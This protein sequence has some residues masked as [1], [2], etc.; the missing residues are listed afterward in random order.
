MTWIDGLWWVYLCA[1]SIILAYYLFFFLRIAL[2]F[3]AAKEEERPDPVSVIIAA[4]NEAGNLKRF[5]PLIM[6]QKGVEFEVVVVNDCS[7][8][9]TQ[10]VLHD[11]EEKYDNFRYTAFCENGD[12]EG[13]KKLAV[14]LGIKAAQYPN[15]V[16]TDADC[17][18]MSEHWLRQMA[19][20]LMRK[21]V[22]LG[23]S[24]YR[25]EQGLLNALIRYDAYRIGLT[26]LALAKAGI[27][28][29]GV[30]RNMGYHSYLFFDQK[31]FSSHMHLASGDDDLFINQIAHG[32]NT[33]TLYT[34]ESMMESLPKNTWRDWMRQKRRHLTTFSEYKLQ[35]Q[36]LLALLPFSQWIFI[37][38]F[39]VML[40]S[41]YKSEWV[42]TLFFAKWI[43]Q[44]VIHFYAMRRLASA[45]LFFKSM[46]LE[47]LLMM[48]Y[49]W[50]AFLKIV[51][52]RHE[53]IWT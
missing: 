46:V 30:G 4:K 19:T 9:E 11:F 47:P 14:S 53:R 13:G 51:K 29:M 28:Y 16:F 50:L 45:N 21:K 8:D 15:L 31:G 33:A 10:D 27:P 1:G 22:V 40:L 49:L 12:F 23:F 48:F 41:N 37:G 39:L 43:L 35:H 52:P 6:N 3:K 38:A 20:T 44:T 5:I 2:P 34:T 26:Y 25:A 7:W 42:L 36:F 18:P 17:Y 32:K 24:P